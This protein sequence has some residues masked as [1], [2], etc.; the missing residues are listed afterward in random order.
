MC[1]YFLT[2]PTATRA[3][4]ALKDECDSA[5]E[6]EVDPA[7][8]DSQQDSLNTPSSTNNQFSNRLQNSGETIASFPTTPTNITTAGT[9]QNK[10]ISF[11][12][13]ITNPVKCCKTAE[14]I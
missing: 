2:L 1:S 5:G 13:Q 9:N 10:V 14:T 12:V 6:E 3:A 7:K 11:P 4:K 8:S